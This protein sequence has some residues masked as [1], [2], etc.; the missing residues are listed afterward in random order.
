VVVLLSR[1]EA[2]VMIGPRWALVPTL[3]Y[4][5]HQPSPHHHRPRSLST[6]GPI[7][8]TDAHLQQRR[9]S[10]REHWAKAGDQPGKSGW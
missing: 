9:A 10:P 3:P 7:G 6:S 8:L 4:H 2:L 5:Q 1:G